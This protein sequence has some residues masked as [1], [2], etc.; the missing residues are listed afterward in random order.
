MKYLKCYINVVINKEYMEIQ[1]YVF[2][3]YKIK[4]VENNYIYFFLEELGKIESLE[5]G[6][7]FIKLEKIKD[8]FFFC[9]YV[10]L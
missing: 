7:W 3:K 2:W 10:G 6:G 5:L 8:V 9:C 4:S 1:K